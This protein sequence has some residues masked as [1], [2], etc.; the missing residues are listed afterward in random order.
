MPRLI[1]LILIA[2]L[3]ACSSGSTAGKSPAK[4]RA[5]CDAGKS[6]ACKAVKKHD[7]LL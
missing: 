7:A 4:L 2:F 6:Y 1:A 5:E 3:C